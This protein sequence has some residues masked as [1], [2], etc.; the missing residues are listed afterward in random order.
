MSGALLLNALAYS[1]LHHRVESTLEWCIE[2]MQALVFL[3]I[4]RTHQC[5]T[6]APLLGGP[7]S[8]SAEPSR[9]GVSAPADSTFS[10]GVPLPLEDARNHALQTALT[11]KSSPR[12]PRVR[13]NGRQKSS[14]GRS[15]LMRRPGKFDVDQRPSPRQLTAATLHR[16]RHQQSSAQWQGNCLR[17]S[18]SPES[19]EARPTGCAPGAH[20]VVHVGQAATC[21]GRRRHSLPLE[22]SPFP[23]SLVPPWNVKGEDRAQAGLFPDWSGGGQGGLAM[24]GQARSKANQR[25]RGSMSMP[26][27]CEGAWARH[28]AIDA[29]VG[30][31]LGRGDISATGPID[32]T[33][34]N[35]TE[36]DCVLFRELLEDFRLSTPCNLPLAIDDRTQ[37]WG[38]EAVTAAARDE[39]SAL[40]EDREECVR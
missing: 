16:H 18:G 14:G 6:A 12:G 23:S 35:L 31:A 17:D 15:Q 2:R 29:Y 30:T 37:A 5:Q 34:G 38:P 21:V 13:S 20:N 19:E 40:E 1:V 26:G 24:K 36:D 8:D 32:G 25:K 3:Q 28:G 10:V 11:P 9:V 22:A 4:P 7:T 27:P 33:G 39:G